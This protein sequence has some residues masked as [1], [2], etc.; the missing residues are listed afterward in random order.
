MKRAGSGARSRS[1]SQ[2]YGSEDPDS[3]Q[4]VTEPKQCSTQYQYSFLG[5]IFGTVRMKSIV[6]V[7]TRELPPFVTSLN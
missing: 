2:R 3:Y 7:E 1:V 6:D 4:N 5:S